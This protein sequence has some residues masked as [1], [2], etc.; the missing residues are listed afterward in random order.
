MEEAVKGVIKFFGMS[1]CDG[2]DKVNITDKF[3][4]LL[5]SGSFMGKELVLVRG[6][7][8]FN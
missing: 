6:Q 8:G 2:S 4:N 3:H 5:L 7:I 1:V